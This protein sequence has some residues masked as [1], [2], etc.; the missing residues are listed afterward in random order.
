MCIRDRHQQDAERLEAGA[1]YMGRYGN[2]SGE[3]S[4]SPNQTAVRIGSNGGM[5][6]ADGHFFVTR[7]LDQSYAVV[8]VA[9]YENVG[10]GIGSNV[11]TRTDKNGIALIPQI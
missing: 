4:Y 8:E 7:R 1:Y 6:L 5:V 11:Q 2:Q 10:I 9:G 3:V